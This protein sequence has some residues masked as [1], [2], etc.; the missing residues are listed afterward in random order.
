[1]LLPL[2]TLSESSSLRKVRKVQISF[3]FPH[4]QPIAS[5]LAWFSFNRKVGR[6]IDRAGLEIRYTPFGYRGFE[7]LTFRKKKFHEQS[8]N[9]FFN[10]L[11]FMHSYTIL[12]IQQSSCE[13]GIVFTYSVIHLFTLDIKVFQIAR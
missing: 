6:V 7:S 8:W 4:V 11:F 5:K 2:H 3:D 13:H 12:C 1:M 9:S 10:P